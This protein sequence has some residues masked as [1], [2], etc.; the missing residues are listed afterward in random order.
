MGPM[1]DTIRRAH[2]LLRQTGV[3]VDVGRGYWTPR[4]E[5]P[6]F[7][8]DR[9]PGRS[10]VGTRTVMALLDAGLAV[11]ARLPPGRAKCNRVRLADPVPEVSAPDEASPRQVPEDHRNS[12][13]SI[14][15][16]SYAN[17]EIQCHR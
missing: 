12:E 14:G 13:P 4:G 6:D 5:Q 7:H 8:A 3:L 11:D 16:T 9:R 1:I 17:Q 15:Q 10:W 2:L